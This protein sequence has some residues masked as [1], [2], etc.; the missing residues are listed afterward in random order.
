MTIEHVR[1][2][3]GEKY[4]SLPDE[5]IQSIIEFIQCVCKFVIATE[6]WSSEPNL[7]PE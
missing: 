2:V 4:N 5:S 3:L 6:S 1:E 7:N